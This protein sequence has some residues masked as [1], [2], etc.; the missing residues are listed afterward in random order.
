VAAYTGLDGIP[1]AWLS[2]R[3]PLPSWLAAATAAGE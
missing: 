2:A 1:P 3:E